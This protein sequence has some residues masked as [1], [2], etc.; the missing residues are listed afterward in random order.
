[1]TRRIAFRMTLETN[2]FKP[3]KTK[4]FNGIPWLGR[5]DSN[6][7]MAESKSAIF[8]RGSRAW[9]ASIVSNRNPNHWGI[10]K[11]V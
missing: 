7:G 5:Q 6:L 8:Y 11:S 1:M 9:D 2:A 4:L 3:N 10:S